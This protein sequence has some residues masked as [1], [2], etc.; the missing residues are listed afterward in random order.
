M[1]I[2]PSVACICTARAPFDQIVDQE[3]VVTMEL[4][5]TNCYTYLEL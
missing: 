4:D 3:D 5:L 1:S 2:L